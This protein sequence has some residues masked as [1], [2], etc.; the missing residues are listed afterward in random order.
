MKLPASFPPLRDL[1]LYAIVGSL[2]LACVPS[3]TA[4]LNA[5]PAAVGLV[6]TLESVSLGIAPSR[7]SAQF[8]PLSPSGFAVTA[9]WA[10]PAHL[11][12]LR[13][14]AR[15]PGASE[16][17]EGITLWAE[18]AGLTNR[19]DS[20]VQAVSLPATNS[21]TPEKQLPSAPRNITLQLEAL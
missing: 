6:A 15:A 16:H 2:T 21:L 17:S 11:T 9:S 1:L 18:P 3:A 19:P 10:V 12:T 20:R 4:Q 7:A 13:V 14:I 8:L 5:R